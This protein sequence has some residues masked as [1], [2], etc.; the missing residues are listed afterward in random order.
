VARRGEII[1]PGSNFLLDLLLSKVHIIADFRWK[2]TKGGNPDVDQID[3]DPLYVHLRRPRIPVAHAFRCA[4]TFA[5]VFPAALPG[6][7]AQVE[8]QG[9]PGLLSGPPGPI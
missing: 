6:A 3:L 9:P 5:H 8:V 1:F 7:P 4:Q 2:R